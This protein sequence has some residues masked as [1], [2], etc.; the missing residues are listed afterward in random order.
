MPSKTVARLAALTAVVTASVVGAAAPA[1]RA[2]LITYCIG[3]GGAVTVPNDLY[4]PAGES[5]SLEGTTV[6]GNV[7][8]AAGSV[9]STTSSVG[10]A[11][12]VGAA[13]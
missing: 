1:A 6:T 4:V 8:V 11:S 12:V 10:S 2:D 3:T 9:G 13:S 7:Q 5:C